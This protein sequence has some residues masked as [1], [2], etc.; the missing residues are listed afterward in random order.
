MKDIL[1]LEQASDILGVNQKFLARINDNRA[2]WAKDIK[3]I[4]IHGKPHFWKDE[5]QKAKTLREER[6]RG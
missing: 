6:K 4:N 1:T 2:S 3:V 5:I